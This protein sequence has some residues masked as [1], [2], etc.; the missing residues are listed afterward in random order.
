MLGTSVYKRYTMYVS[1]FIGV[2]IVYVIVVVVGR[3]IYQKQKK[4]RMLSISAGTNIIP[5]HSN[6]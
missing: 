5:S 6:M 2:Y 1:G 4:S 3:Y